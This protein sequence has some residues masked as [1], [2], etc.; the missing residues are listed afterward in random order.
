[1][2]ALNINTLSILEAIK[3]DCAGTV[4]HNNNGEEKQMER[5]GNLNFNH[6]INLEIGLLIESCWCWLRNIL[7]KFKN[8]NSSNPSIGED[9]CR[10]RG[11]SISI[12]NIYKSFKPI[13]ERLLE[14]SNDDNTIGGDDGGRKINQ[15][16]K[17]KLNDHLLAK[18]KRL[19]VNNDGH[20]S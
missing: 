5:N 9:N 15:N 8:K 16:F 6:E 7:I 20:R 17:Q 13:M 12:C 10:I 11:D 18:F 4:E 2:L 3:I 14:I 1:M 19:N